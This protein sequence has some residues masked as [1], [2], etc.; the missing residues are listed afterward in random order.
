[1]NLLIST[2]SIYIRN[3]TVKNDLDINEPQL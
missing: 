2:V 3:I 1:M